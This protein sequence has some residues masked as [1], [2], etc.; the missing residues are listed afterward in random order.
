MRIWRYGSG[1]G[2]GSVRG[3]TSLDGVLDY[4][5]DLRGLLAGHRDG[6]KILKH[7]GAVPLEAKIAGTLTAPTLRA[8]QYQQILTKALESA[9]RGAAR[10]AI[11]RG[12]RDLFKKKRK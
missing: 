9:A 8:P 7:L 3:T 11:E 2:S 5:L 4:Q 10:G 1:I 6:K 12:L